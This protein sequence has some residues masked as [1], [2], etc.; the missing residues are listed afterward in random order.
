MLRNENLTQKLTSFCKKINIDIIGFADP[1]YF[2]KYYHDNRLEAFLENSNT[3]IVIGLYLYDLVL[4]AWSKDITK[5]KNYHFADSILANQCYVIKNFLTKKGFKS[6]IIPYEPGFY[7]KDTAALAGIGPIGRNNL[8]LT[9][10][11]GPQVRLRALTTEAALLVGTPIYES[12][13]CEDCNICIKACPANA[14]A[15]GKYN[16]DACLAYCLANLENL[17]DNTNL[18][19]NICIESCPV[20][21]KEK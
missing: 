11:Y 12:K 18:W 13:F 17:S 2:D 21:K 15:E 16:K 7:L 19:C 8:L 5:N 20:G 6:K 9:K 1:I 4:D 3:I 14:F 10:K